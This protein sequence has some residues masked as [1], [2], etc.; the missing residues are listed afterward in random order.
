MGDKNPKSKEKN[1]KQK[2]LGK[3]NAAKKVQTEKEAKAAN[4]GKMKK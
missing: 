3:A 1:Q 2:N 4:S